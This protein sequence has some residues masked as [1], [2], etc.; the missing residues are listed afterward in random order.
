MNVANQFQEG[1]VF[2]AQNRFVAVLEKLAVP[3]IRRSHRMAWPV[4]SRRITVAMGA[5]PVLNR[6]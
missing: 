2:P 6:R 3:L 5:A 4:G 1:A